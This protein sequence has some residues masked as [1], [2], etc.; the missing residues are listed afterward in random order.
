M[1]KALMGEIQLFV[2]LGTL[3]AAP[4]SPSETKSQK[5][6][7]KGGEQPRGLNKERFTATLC[8]QH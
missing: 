6:K 4:L 7:R 5:Q 8:I 3:R 1:N 2:A